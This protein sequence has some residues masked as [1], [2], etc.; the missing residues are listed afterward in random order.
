[1]RRVSVRDELQ[2]PVKVSQVAA[3]LGGAR[4]RPTCCEKPDSDMMAARKW[5][6]E[7]TEPSR[8]RRCLSAAAAAAAAT[9]PLSGRHWRCHRQHMDA[10]RH[11]GAGA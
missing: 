9:W 11:E 6:Q 1:M 8:R 2:Q 5:L 7:P 10:Q 3:A 4:A